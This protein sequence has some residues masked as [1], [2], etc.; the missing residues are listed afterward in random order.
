MSDNSIESV[1][2]MVSQNPDIINK[3]SSLV[4]AGG[5]DMTKSLSSVISLISQNQAENKK[6]VDSSVGNEEKSDTPTAEIKN[7]N[8]FSSNLK[9]DSFLMTLSKSIAKN[10]S[11]LLALKPYLSKN[12][13]EIIDTVVKISQLANVMNLAK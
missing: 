5:D 9:S 1:L 6:S 3:I 4:E 8:D 13:C 10:S 7:I 2:T 12:R 11:L